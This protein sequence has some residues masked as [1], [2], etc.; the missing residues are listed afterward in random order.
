VDSTT[1]SSVVYYY[2]KKYKIGSADA[3]NGPHEYYMVLRLAEQYLIRAEARAMLG[4]LI[5]SIDDTNAI[6]KRAGL[7]SLPNSLTQQQVM[8][9]IKQEN[10]IEFFAEWGH[11]WLDLKRWEAA[12]AILASVKGSNWQAFDKLYPIPQYEINTASNISQ[13]DGY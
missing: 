8:D 6:R 9:A 12:D 11:R 4:K 7:A 2:P 13:N 10:R 1:S 5:A 3:N